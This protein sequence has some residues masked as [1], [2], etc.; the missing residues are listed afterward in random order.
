MDESLVLQQRDMYWNTT[1]MMK[2]VLSTFASLLLT[3]PSVT[4]GSELPYI[5]PKKMVRLNFDLNIQRWQEQHLGAGCRFVYFLLTS[6]LLTL[7]IAFE[8]R[9]C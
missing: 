9:R 1:G 3:V 4:G 2:Y 6:S 7:G 5:I 8:S